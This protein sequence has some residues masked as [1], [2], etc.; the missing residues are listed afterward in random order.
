MDIFNS[1][2]TPLLLGALGFYFLVN[3]SFHLLRRKLYPDGELTPNQL[4]TSH[5][6]LLWEPKANICYRRPIY[7]GLQ[8]FLYEHGHKVFSHRDKNRLLESYHFFFLAESLEEIEEIS[9]NSPEKVASLNL[10]YH[11]E[12]DILRIDNFRFK[13]HIHQVKVPINQSTRSIIHLHK[14]LCQLPLGLNIDSISLGA[15]QS[16]EYY[17]TILL[18]TTELAERDLLQ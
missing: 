3:E 15:L 12:K 18:H 17:E 8:S 11:S 9:Q 2:L 14:L 13:H 7:N 6:I 1:H 4:L 10:L 16:R 5:P